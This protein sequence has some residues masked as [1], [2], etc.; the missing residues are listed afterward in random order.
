M[1]EIVTLAFQVSS[2][3][4]LTEPANALYFSL[5]VSSRITELKSIF[6]VQNFTT[7]QAYSQTK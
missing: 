4:E 3:L 7:I 5:A 1:A 6:N 2:V